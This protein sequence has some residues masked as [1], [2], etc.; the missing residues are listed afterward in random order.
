[1][2][3]LTKF[4]CLKSKTFVPAGFFRDCTKVRKILL[5]FLRKLID[6]CLRRLQAII[7]GQGNQPEILYTQ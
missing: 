7:N 4:H 5:K 1:M 6:S 2:Q 3:V